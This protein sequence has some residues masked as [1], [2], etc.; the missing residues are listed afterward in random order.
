MRGRKAQ[1]EAFGQKLAAAGVFRQSSRARAAFR[2]LSSTD[3][4]DLGLPDEFHPFVAYDKLAR[5]LRPLFHST[6]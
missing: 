1:I 2:R 4:L 5:R 6:P 3:F